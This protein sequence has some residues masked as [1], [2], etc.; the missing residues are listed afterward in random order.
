MIESYLPIFAQIVVA[1]VLGIALSTVGILVGPKRTTAQKLTTY[2]SGVEP[3]GAAKE[4]VSVKYYLV[5]ML[6]IV[7][8]IEVVF[9]YPWAVSFREFGFAGLLSMLTFAL[10]LLAGYFYIVKKGGLDW[11]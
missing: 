7:F 9:M 2:E 11:D 6:F 10:T 4:R 5:A 3:V 1:I 8:D